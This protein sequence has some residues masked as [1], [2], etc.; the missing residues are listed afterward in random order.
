MTGWIWAVLAAA[1]AQGVAGDPGVKA[2]VEA[3]QR[4]DH[5]AAVAAWRPLADRGDAH[6]QF[7]LAQAYKLGRGAPADMGKAIDLYRKAAAQGHQEAG[8][9][10]GLILF[11]NGR[12]QEAMPYLIKAAE[13]GEASA[14]YV[15]GTALFNGDIVKQ[16]LALAYAMMTRAASQGLPPAVTT[17]AEM[18][19]HIPLAERQKAVA[20]TRSETRVASAAVPALRPAPRP[21]AGPPPA[22]VRPVVPAPMRA[23]PAPRAAP[24]ATA[25]ATP[26]A[27]RW[28]VQLGAFGQPANANALFDGLKGRVPA[29]RNAQAY[30][31]RAGA[32]TRL[33]AGP[34]AS[35][36][37][38]E[39][40]CRAIK[41][42]GQACFPVAP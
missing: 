5:A 40:A 34:Y 22:P 8:S 15:Y 37:A 23:T 39:D 4:G 13:A 1:A 18:D 26:P 21:D 33:Q 17:L 25:A 3:W 42:T 20:M 31:I 14:Q 9:L 7:N 12:R 27:G 6:A 35:R 36:A 28:R 2:G 24:V 38:A 11:Q 41:A 19:K 16:D 30:L 32:L 10:L 29:L